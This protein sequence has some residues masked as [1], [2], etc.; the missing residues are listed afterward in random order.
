[1]ETDGDHRRFRPSSHGHFRAV[2]PVGVG[3]DRRHEEMQEPERASG[4]EPSHLP[5]R[6]AVRTLTILTIHEF[7]TAKGPSS[8]T[9]P[10]RK[11]GHCLPVRLQN[12]TSG[13]QH[14][15]ICRNGRRGRATVLCNPIEIGSVAALSPD[16][17]AFA[18]T[19]RKGDKVRDGSQSNHRG[20]G[21]QSRT[22]SSRGSRREA[23]T[24]SLPI[25]TEVY[26]TNSDSMPPE[27]R[28]R[29]RA[30]H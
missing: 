19:A 12:R 29:S 25:G 17:A 3:Y 15:M 16:I 28:R 4:N 8:R 5:P 7:L 27:R 11:P 10:R 26:P 21:T 2:P 30:A 6:S 1:M 14:R 13:W 24:V 20:R 22:T 18:R 23:P 9:A